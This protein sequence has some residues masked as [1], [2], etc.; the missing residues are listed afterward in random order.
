M[1]LELS[2]RDQPECFFNRIVETLTT[3][4]SKMEKW[5]RE[6]NLSPIVPEGGYF[7]L[8]RIDNVGKKNRQ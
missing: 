4:K 2:R 8:A 7:M 3:K 1:E 6:A 5:L